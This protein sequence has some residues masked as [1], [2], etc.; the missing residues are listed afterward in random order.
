VALRAANDRLNARH[1][2]AMIKWL[3]Q[4]IV[5]ANAALPMRLRRGVEFLAS[6]F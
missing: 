6:L 2:L 5:G 1:Q 3:G 4:E